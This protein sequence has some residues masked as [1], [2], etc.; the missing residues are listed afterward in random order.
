MSE[1]K[2]SRRQFLVQG[3]QSSAL[4]WGA[5]AAN[6]MCGTFQLRC[7]ADEA[8]NRPKLGYS[9]YGMRS[10]TTLEAM[11][12]CRETGWEVA[13][14][15]VMSDWPADSAK[16]SAVDLRELSKR[17]VDLSLPITCLMENLA[18]LT[19]PEKHRDNLDRLKRAADVAHALSPKNPP[20]VETILGG[21]PAEWETAKNQMAITLGAWKEVAV[22]S[23]IVIAIKPHVFGALHK[24]DDCRWLV[25]QLN[26]PAIRATFDYSHF[27]RQGLDF[28]TCLDHLLPV[29]AFIHIKDNQKVGEQWSFVLPGDGMTDYGNYFQELSRRKYSGS[30]VVETS[31]QVFSKKD[32][33]PQAATRRCHEKLLP[34]WRRTF[35]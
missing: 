30:V 10:L 26:S 35:G 24:P 14:I 25:D 8:P 3:M 1:I 20:V 28:K 33:D 17:S 29:T 2:H 4:A 9:I 34:V 15:P 32:Y 27:E 6:S 18:L 12:L 19:S 13:E 16:L 5:V 7:H 11:K 23:K 31:A 21:K 22:S